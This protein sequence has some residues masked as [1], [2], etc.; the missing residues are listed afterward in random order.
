M[1]LDLGASVSHGAAHCVLDELGQ[2]LALSK[3]RL[4]VCAKLRVNA[5]LWKDG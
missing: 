2:G 5:H 1:K 4:Q 3:H